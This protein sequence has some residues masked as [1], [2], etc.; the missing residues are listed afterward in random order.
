[1]SL[2]DASICSSNHAALA[3][4]WGTKGAPEEPPSLPFLYKQ[5]SL[6]AALTH[7]PT[8][9]YGGALFPHPPRHLWVFGVV[10]FFLM[11]AILTGVR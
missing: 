9:A 8:S 4:E 10:L 3:P 2:L 7:I 11:M 5:P 6:V 1:M